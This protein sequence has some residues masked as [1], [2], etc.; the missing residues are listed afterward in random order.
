MIKQVQLKKSE[1]ELII[2]REKEVQFQREREESE[3]RMIIEERQRQEEEMRKA[4]HLALKKREELI[5]KVESRR[6]VAFSLLENADNFLKQYHPDFDKAIELY[7][8][9]KNILLEINWEPE[10]ANLD[11]LIRNL[12]E[13]KQKFITRQK[14]EEEARIRAAEEYEK[15]EQEVLR[16]KLDVQRVQEEQRL[17][18]ESF[19]LEQEQREQLQKEG[20]DLLDDAKKSVAMNHF[21]FAYEQFEQAI[22]KFKSIGWLEQTKYIKK[23]IETTKKLEENAIKAQ[24]EVKKSQEALL[25]QKE[26]DLL[27][28]IEEEAVKKQ[29]VKTINALSDD[30]VKSLKNQRL[31]QERTQVVVKKEVKMDAAKFAK[32]LGKMIKI[33]QDL[34]SEI[35]KSDEEE[36]KKRVEKEKRKT[37]EELK[38]LH[39]WIKEAGKKSE[40][41]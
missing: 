10:I 29:S 17:K 5:A 26:L 21:T 20:F 28:R 25:R 30:I 40:E 8:E 12:R 24:K 32:D 22:E 1:Q 13:E 23:E 4:K 11:T 38:E 31:E 37:K 35:A 18:L 7:L 9:A 6:E 15:F 36:K 27:R 19:K 34:A 2:Q 3:L 14:Q 41:E 39:K 33:K 16:K